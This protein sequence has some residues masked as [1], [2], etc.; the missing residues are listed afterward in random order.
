MRYGTGSIAR[1]RIC[2]TLRFK[3][4]QLSRQALCGVQI[5]K[6]LTA[7]ECAGLA[8][9][10]HA[11]IYASNEQVLSD[12]DKT[13][14]VYF[15]ISGKV[16]ATIFS[17]TGKE[18][19]FRDMGPGSTFGD[20]SAIDGQARSANIITLEDSLIAWMS[21]ENFWK[22]L[23]QHPVVSHAM[24]KIL[25]GL[26]RR[27]SERV[28]EFSTLGAKNRLHAE[29]LRLARDS[30]LD[31]NT[32]RIAPPPTHAEIA[33]RISSHREA[34][35]RELHKLAGAGLLERRKG[36]LIVHDVDRLTQMVSQVK[37]E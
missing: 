27:L 24:L 32:A 35:T 19:T 15:I 11:G 22:T 13:H 5:F 23:E 2:P 14:D 9:L 26:I 16:R 37:G 29:L 8:K 33:S 31:E 3:P 28:V 18:V 34:V 30:M 6:D 21:A 25:T 12:K 1:L 36:E 7:G 17:A 10:C 4:V 20:L